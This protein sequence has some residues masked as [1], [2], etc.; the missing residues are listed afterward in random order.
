MVI[1]RKHLDRRTFLRGAG[2]VI[3]LP[4]L[5]AMIPAFAPLAKAAVRPVRRLAFVYF[6]N[7]MNMAQWLPTAEGAGFELSPL[8]RVLEP[9]KQQM[10]VLSGLSQSAGKSLPGEGAGD[11]ARGCATYLTGVHCKKTQGFDIRAGVSADQIAAEHLGKETQLASLEL[12]L[13]SISLAGSCDFDY[14]CTYVNTISWR[15][16]TTPNPVE[17]SPR[18]VFERLFG[19]GP[20]TDAHVR[21]ER[22]HANR[23]ILDSVLTDFQQ[24]GRGLGPRDR[25]KLAEYLD[26]VREVERGIQ[27]AEAQADRELPVID[28]PTDVPPSFEAHAKLMLDLNVLAFQADLTRVS[29]FMTGREVSNRAYPEIGVPDA[30]HPVSH[31]QNDAGKLERLAKINAF[32][33]LQVRHFLEKLKATQEADGGSLLD[34]SLVVCG[35]SLSD[36]NAHLHD[37]LPLVA[38]GG[39]LKGDRHLRYP[40]GTPLNNLWMTVLARAGVRA[41]HLGDASG[42]FAELSEV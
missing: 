9:F 33:L 40:R 22:L 1:T 21:A 26:A 5:D 25:V 41:E 17:I 16:P 12:G 14:S 37:D 19:D 39:G 3:A 34:H 24:L 4:V 30:H 32:H 23:S 11:H 42:E 27:Q 15:N 36:S 35:A 7:G 31:H 10:V 20:N 8:L 38:I 6:P 18:V 29:T 28:R 2:A 13:D